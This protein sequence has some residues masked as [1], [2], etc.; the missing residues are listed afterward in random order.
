[1]TLY[2]CLWLDNTSDNVIIIDKIFSDLRCI[3]KSKL[4]QVCQM[5]YECVTKL[6]LALCVFSLIHSRT[7]HSVKYLLLNYKKYEKTPINSSKPKQHAMQ[8][9]N[10]KETT[11]CKTPTSDNPEHSQYRGDANVVGDCSEKPTVHCE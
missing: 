4:L 2:D 6:T 10:R 8:V 11:N 9:N 7:N 3:L 1:M 5:G